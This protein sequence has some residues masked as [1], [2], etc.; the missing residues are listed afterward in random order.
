MAIHVRCSACGK[1]YQLADEQAGL[2]VRCREC[3]GEFEVPRKPELLEAVAALPAARR[4]LTPAE[5][6]TI[7][8]AL[9]K[10]KPG[11]RKWMYIAGGLTAVLM[12]LMLACSGTLLLL[13]SQ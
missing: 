10:P 11:G 9:T 1:D 8:R 3:Q 7:N 13:L 6:E 2:R 12:L 4:P 5:S